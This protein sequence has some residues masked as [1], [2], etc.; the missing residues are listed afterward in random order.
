M[1]YNYNHVGKNGYKNVSSGV[2]EKIFLAPVGWFA[3]NGI[4]SPTAPFTNPGDEITVTETHQFTEGKG[5]V[6]HVCAPGKNTLAIN[7]RGAAGTL[8]QNQEVTVFI[9]GN[10]EEVH[11]QVKNMINT[12]L[13]GLI[14]DVNCASGPCHQLG[15]DC[16]A[17]WMSN[18]SWASA[19]SKEGEKGYNITFQFDGSPLFYK[20]DITLKP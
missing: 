6:E 15:S 4:K 10:M 19:T 3:A 11:E 20:G 17:L 14:K 7:T 8:S 18:A 2:S 5:F 1:S 13:I 9:P 12:P 16:Q